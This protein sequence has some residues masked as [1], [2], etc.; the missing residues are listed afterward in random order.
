VIISVDF[1][2]TNQLLVTYSV[3]VRYRH[4]GSIMG[5]EKLKGKIVPVLPR[6]EDVLGE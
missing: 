3:F 6:H 2:V 1:E 4:N 5:K